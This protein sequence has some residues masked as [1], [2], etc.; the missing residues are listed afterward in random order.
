MK[1]NRTSRK[2]EQN[3][4]EMRKAPA[5]VCFLRELHFFTLL[6]HLCADSRRIR[7]R[8]RKKRR[9]KLRALLGPQPT[10]KLPMKNCFSDTLDSSSPL[11]ENCIINEIYFPLHSVSRRFPVTIRSILIASSYIHLNAPQ[12]LVS[13]DSPVKLQAH[14]AYAVPTKCHSVHITF[15]RLL[16]PLL[17]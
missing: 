1:D 14:T 12:V 16:L 8:R 13:S 9:K 6:S 5:H 11:A 2:N 3:F 15:S 7:R 10:Y 17:S 4:V